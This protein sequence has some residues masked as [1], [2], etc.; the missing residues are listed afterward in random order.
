M[1]NATILG[2]E[3][4]AVTN[5]EKSFFRDSDPLGFI[6]FARNVDSP[7]QL[8]R[9]TSDLRSAVGRDAPILIDQ[10]GGR[11]QRMRA[12]H[13]R[14][15][16]PPLEQAQKSH[17]P[18]RSFWLR[19]RIMASELRAV[20][21]DVNCAPTCDIASAETHPFLQNRCLGTDPDTVVQNARATAD[22]LLAGGVIPVMKHMPGHGRTVVD[23]HLN[24]P[25]A[26]VARETAQA[27][28]FAPFKALADLPMGM[29]AHIIFSAF[30]SKPATQDS[31]M[32]DL[33]R[34]QIGFDGF[35]MSDDISMEALDGDLTRRTARSIAAGCDAVLHCNG[36]PKEMEEVVAAAGDLTQPAALR[37]DRALSL[38]DGAQNVDIAALNAELDTLLA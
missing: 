11:V 15:W 18:A 34:T 7:D 20:G 38:R 13:W 1:T 21:I 3:G 4:H 10:E 30:G 28:D 17:D 24:L 12:P 5:W 9:L 25:T 22:G 35:L 8:Y 26:D 27:W 36:K 6:V 29:T 2:P 14:E 32:I 23:S 31:G 16:V 33:I 37:A 19:S